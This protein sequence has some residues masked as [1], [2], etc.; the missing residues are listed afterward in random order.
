[1]KR[2]HTLFISLF[3]VV[4]I[5][6]SCGK[7]EREAE[8]IVRTA[9]I[10]TVRPTGGEQMSIYPG[11]VRS[12]IDASLSFRVAGVISHMPYGEG[13]FVRKGTVI[14]E[15]EAQDYRLQLAAAE[16]EYNQVKALAERVA[17]LYKRGSTT[18]SEYEKA[19]YGL[20]QITAKYEH[21]QNQVA[22]TRL[23][24]PFDGYVQEKIHNVGETVNAGMSVISMTGNGEWQI[25]INLPVQ[26]YARKKDFERFEACISTAPDKKFPL[27][28]Y[29]L[30]PKGNANQ[31]YK[32]TFR[33]GKSG[34][35]TLAAGMSTEVTIFYQTE[36]QA[37]YE[38]PVSALFE[39]EGN[40]YVWIFT[41]EE[42]P[43]EARPVKIGSMNRNG[44]FVVKE[45]IANGERIVTA[46]VHSLKDG[47][48]V[49][50]LPGMNE[51]NVGGLL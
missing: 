40:P 12:S 29:E 18:Q 19:V 39:R 36:Q 27:E 37:V 42:K 43:V 14:A 5:V 9:K 23:T 46:G 7:K 15:L 4:M 17:E 25:E 32:T 48:K 31:S 10:D 26:D 33:V 11:I 13:H 45:G 3:S 21:S 8:A 24:A 47:A 20:E 41:S 22:Y 30:S 16:A 50:P 49:K 34:D 28:L 2:N 35:L 38:I 44:Y 51:S 1:M 6:S